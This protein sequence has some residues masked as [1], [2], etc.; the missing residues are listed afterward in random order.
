MSFPR[1][2]YFYFFL[3]EKLYK[4]ACS[5]FKSMCSVMRMIKLKL[6]QQKP[7]MHSAMWVCLLRAESLAHDVHIRISSIL[8]KRWLFNII[9]QKLEKKEGLLCIC[10]PIGLEW[11]L[12]SQAASP[13]DEKRGV[14]RQRTSS[15]SCKKTFLSPLP[16]VCCRYSSLSISKKRIKHQCVGSQARS[17]DLIWSAEFY[18]LG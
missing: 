10:F 6:N 15:I 13:I 8:Q 17:S 4:K 18:I 7:V 2:I 16:P 11:F 5:H 1:R 12:L 14:W 9:L 3:L